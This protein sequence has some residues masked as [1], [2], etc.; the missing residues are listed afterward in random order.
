[1]SAR[2]SGAAPT[3]LAACAFGVSALS[4]A[5]SAARAAAPV[6]LPAPG[7]SI[8]AAP[9]SVAPSA[10]ATSANAS[11]ASADWPAI[12]K[13]PEFMGGVWTYDQPSGTDGAHAPAQPKFREGVTA[14][15]GSAPMCEPRGVPLDIGGA[16]F[17]TKDA[18]FL[19]TDFD[20]FV[21]RRIDMARREHGEPEPTY[22]GDSLGRWDGRTLI[23]DTTGFLPQVQIAEGYPGN[24]KTQLI[25]KFKMTA[26]DRIELELTVTNPELLQEPWVTTRVL[27]RHPG[28]SLHESY[29]ITR[30]QG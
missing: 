2:R 1:M 10:A 16:F 12:A 4:V 9:P 23:V 27:T 5:Q 30:P 19:M 6:P 25:E 20:Y 21:V 13:W 29:C 15:S 26:Q 8:P 28:W 18:V 3:L 22:Y 17:F 24:S 14:Q 11:A 7:M